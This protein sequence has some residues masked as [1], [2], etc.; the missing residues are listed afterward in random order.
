M[1]QAKTQ[2]KQELDKKVSS[3]QSLISETV[4][5][6]TTSEE[7]DHKV[8]EAA[9][10]VQLK[11]AVKAKGQVTTKSELEAAINKELKPLVPSGYTIAEIVSQKFTFKKTGGFDVFVIA[12]LLPKVDLEEM[13]KMLAGRKLEQA[14]EYI[15]TV[16]SVASV[17]FSISP[18]LPFVN[19][20][21]PWIA[22]HIKIEIKSQ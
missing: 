9:D 5:Y 13:V 20:R 22:S 3:E 8:D 17:N 12:K 19:S 7:L 2:A 21:L 4:V 1:D 14:K 16:P 15:Q 11:L 18:S 6:T 10:N